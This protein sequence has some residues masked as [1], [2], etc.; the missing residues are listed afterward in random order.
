MPHQPVIVQD[1]SASVLTPVQTLGAQ[2]GYMGND[3][4]RRC[5]SHGMGDGPESM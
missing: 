2:D 5:M 3:A 4:K 1:R